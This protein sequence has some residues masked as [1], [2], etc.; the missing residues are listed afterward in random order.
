M[1]TTKMMKDINKK[2]PDVFSVEKKILEGFYNH[3]KELTDIYV[4]HRNGDTHKVAYA[5]LKYA[6]DEYRRIRMIM[7]HIDA[8][9]GRK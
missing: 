3:D 2:I 1:I 9:L 8:H 6:N 5:A 7:D 4:A